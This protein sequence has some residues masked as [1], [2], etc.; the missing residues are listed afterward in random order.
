[1]SACLSKKYHRSKYNALIK[2]VFKVEK[3]VNSQYS[4]H[5]DNLAEYLRQLPHNADEA[6]IRNSFITPVFF[7]ALG[8]LLQEQ[9]AEFKTREN[10]RSVDFALRHNIDNS[11]IFSHTLINPHVLVELKARNYNLEFGSKHYKST[12]KQIK[13]YLLAPKSKSAQWGIIT[14]S[15]HIQLFRKHGKSIFPATCC[16]EINPDNI[17][18]IT[19]QI[20]KKIEDTSRALTVAVYNNKGGVGKTT[21]VINLAATLTRH[22][23]KVL[24]IDFDPNQHDLTDSLNIQLGNRHFYDCLKD[25]QNLVDIKQTIC[26]YTKTFRGGITL[27]FDVIPVDDQLAKNE[28]EDI[29]KEISL[30]SLRK[31]LESLKYDY[32]YILIDAP[33]NWRYYSISALYA[34]DVVLMPTKHNSIASLKNAAKTITQYIPEIQRVR[35]EKTKGLE[36]GAIA[37]PIFFNGGKITDAATVRAKNAIATIIKQV[38]SEHK[39]DLTPY[40]FP[41][42]KPGNNT[43]IFEMPN[44][45]HIANSAFDSIPAAYRYRV[46]YDY[47]S[48]L[49]KEYFL[50]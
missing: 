22:K 26:S 15:K 8:F 3:E 24:V 33:P 48:Q 16:I 43:S 30:H 49:A 25:K 36:W 12:V 7:P 32:D 38:K 11:D 20:R 42:Y 19:S 29:R 5:D 39:F 41:R 6:T 45:A 47:Y 2:M 27:S 18:E 21:T 31:K 40:F 46:A 13:D 9:K 44:S 35:Q 34:S 1:M 23:K 28:E 50:Q 10:K 14:N 4:K 17:A 37:L